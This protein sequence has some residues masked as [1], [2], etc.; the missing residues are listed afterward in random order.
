MGAARLA[1]QKGYDVFVSDFGEISK[2][3]RELLLTEGISFEENG[4]SEGSVLN[5]NLIIKS[6]GISPRIPI[7]KAARE[8]GI[9]IIDELEFAFRYSE[10]KVIAITGTNGKTTTTSMIYHV[11]KSA[12]MDVGVAGNIGQ[13]WASQLLDSDHEWWVIE[14]SS[15]QIEGM[16]SFRP[17]I[18]IL[19][20]ITPD[21]LN[22]YEYSL[23]KYI[24]AKFRLFKNQ[25]ED[26]FA[27]FLK[28]DENSD[29][30]RSFSSISSSTLEVGDT[31]EAS[32][33]VNGDTLE[34]HFDHQNWQ[35][36]VDEI[37]VPGRHNQLNVLF[38]GLACQLAKLSPQAIKEGISSFRGIKHR[39]EKVR[40]VDGVTF[41]NDSKGTNVDATSYA[42]HSYERP[43]VWIAGGVDKGNDYSM[44]IDI[45]KKQVKGLICLGKDNQKLKSVF[46]DLVEDIRETQA[47]TQ[48]V[49]WGHEIGTDGDVILLSP[50]C[51]SFDLFNNYEDRGNQFVEAVNQL[52]PKVLV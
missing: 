41:V 19:T 40:V 12:G 48:A 21:H 10:G 49:N 14:C 51:A 47:M 27:I 20:N 18:G 3:N 39:M 38:T 33:F 9:V 31:N 5:A 13:S 44:I 37:P 43:L 11:M 30:G 6:P 8:K 2:D 17:H 26:D 25:T 50:A 34:F 28:G 52:K 36:K 45:V 4:H 32:A 16:K 29:K 46:G 15:F 24:R 42:L 35:L 1:K 23:D 7:L 22:R